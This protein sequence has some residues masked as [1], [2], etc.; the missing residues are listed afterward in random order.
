LLG[1]RSVS[2]ERVARL[3]ECLEAGLNPLAASRAAGVS[4]GFA[5]RVDRERAGVARR[6]VQRAAAAGRAEARA[7][8]ARAAAERERRVTGLLASGLN[9]LAA[10]RAAG[11]SRGYAYAL[12][13]RRAC[14][15]ICVRRGAGVAGVTEVAP[16][17]RIY[18][19]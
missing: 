3:V 19:P 18:S 6:A 1:G 13:A 15:L 12:N 2:A 10:S 4:H 16:A 8:R 11:V 14:L 17:G 9:P 5:Y 7:V